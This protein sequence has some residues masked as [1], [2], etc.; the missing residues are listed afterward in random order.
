MILED[1]QKEKHFQ[2]SEMLNSL[3]SGN[4][5]TNAENSLQ[6]LRRQR[7]ANFKFGQTFMIL[8]DELK[9]QSQ[10]R[11]I[12]FDYL[13]LTLRH[14]TRIDASPRVNK[15]YSAWTDFFIKGSEPLIDLDQHKMVNL[16]KMLPPEMVYRFIVH[17]PVYY[18]IVKLDLLQHLEG[19]GKSD[20]IRDKILFFKLVCKFRPEKAHNFIETLEA[21]NYQKC[22]QISRE[23]GNLLAQAYIQFKRGRYFDS[24]DLYAKM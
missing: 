6:F 24:F 12:I 22:L 17:L 1:I 13:Y 9:S 3:K 7:K 16:V 2:D 11:S 4:L 18:S 14:L 19:L 8:L 15:E 23:E 10:T 5:G 21:V 20:L